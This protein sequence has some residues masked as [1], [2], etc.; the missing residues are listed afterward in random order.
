MR[1]T[2]NKFDRAF[3][4]SVRQ[5]RQALGDLGTLRELFSVSKRQTEGRWYAIHLE[6]AS[7]FLHG[8]TSRLDCSLEGRLL[9]QAGQIP[10]S[11]CVDIDRLLRDIWTSR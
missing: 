5:S 1:D 8:D 11:C 10:R 6:S 4:L 7:T 9:P 2:F 3:I